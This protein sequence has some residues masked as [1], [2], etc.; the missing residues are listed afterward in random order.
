MKNWIEQ[1]VFIKRD[2]PL[3]DNKIRFLPRGTNSAIVLSEYAKESFSLAFN[4]QYYVFKQI[5]KE[6]PKLV[7]SNWRLSEFYYESRNYVPICRY[8][9]DDVVEASISGLNRFEIRDALNVLISFGLADDELLNRISELIGVNENENAIYNATIE[10]LNECF[11][12]VDFSMSHDAIKLAKRADTA[13]NH[14]IVF[15]LAE[16]LRN[17]YRSIYSASGTKI[18]Y[19]D[20]CNIQGVIDLYKSIDPSNPDYSKATQQ[21]KQMEKWGVETLNMH[22]L[23]SG[24]TQKE[25]QRITRTL[26]S[27][28]EYV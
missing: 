6:L 15:K 7:C 3:P 21:A 5:R 1:V 28:F 8:K 19:F 18:D 25:D 26:S 13:G 22:R 2:T 9:W 16:Y 17:Y 12:I 27:S 24:K 4:V 23:F 10:L 20:E 11:G 14:S